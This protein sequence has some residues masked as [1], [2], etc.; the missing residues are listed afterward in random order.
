[1]VFPRGEQ[2][3]TLKLLINRILGGIGASLG[4]LSFVL[5]IRRKVTIEN[6]REA[7][8]DW[9]EAE[10]G[11]T[12]RDSARN[13]GRV[14]FEMVYLRYAHRDKIAAGFNLRNLPD[15]HSA[16]QGSKGAILLSGHL[17]NWEWMAVGT[18]LATGIPLQVIVKNQTT[19]RI[20][21]FLQTMRGRFGNGLIPAGDVRAIF[22][23]LD[24]GEILGILGDQTAFPDSVFVPFFGRDVPTFEGSAR[25]A[26]RS[27]APLLL[28]ECWREGGIYQA[29]SHPVDYSDIRGSGPEA[30][31][32][33]T[34]RHTALLETI[35]RKRPELW[36]WQHKRWKHAK[37][38]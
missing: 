38:R 21:N 6:L 11:R 36:L 24:R 28:V 16:L 30:V 32:E 9:S 3:D 33:L 2:T 4:L 5:G 18:G 20:E 23:A 29:V 19:G 12:A 27:R 13:L 34:R 17:A 26:L 25:L 8:P 31:A 10:L 15:V 35:I 7:Y 37:P 14:F 22:R 1:M